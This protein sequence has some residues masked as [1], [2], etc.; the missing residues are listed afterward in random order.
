MK[1]IIN[2]Y[3]RHKSRA[4]ETVNYQTNNLK[5]IDEYLGVGSKYSVMETINRYVLIRFNRFF[6]HRQRSEK[7]HIAIEGQSSE[8]N[9]DAPTGRGPELGCGSFGTE[10][11]R[12]NK[13]V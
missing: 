9:T 1:F 3:P 4:K 2:L 13:L 7:A 12:K 11:Q 10:P 6:C 5:L 8:E